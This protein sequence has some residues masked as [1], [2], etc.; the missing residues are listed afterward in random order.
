MK[1]AGIAKHHFRIG[2]IDRCWRW[3]R[4][5]AGTAAL[6]AT[7]AAWAGPAAP[8]LV[9]ARTSDQ[10]IRPSTSSTAPAVSPGSNG[11]DLPIG[12]D[13]QPLDDSALSRYRGAGENSV[14]PDTRTHVGVILWDER[15]SGGQGGGSTKS[16]STGY[17]NTQATSV[18]AVRIR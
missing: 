9:V 17:G 8:E 12:F 10:L 18:V 15:G 5:V 3:S 14:A 7:V 1:T 11:I 2:P 16:G 4:W 13:Q 6:F